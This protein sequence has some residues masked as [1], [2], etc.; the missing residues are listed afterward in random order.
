[1]EKEQILGLYKKSAFYEKYKGT[2]VSDKILKEV[3][4]ENIRVH[5]A[6]GL[7]TYAQ[8]HQFNVDVMKDLLHLFMLD[9]GFNDEAWIWRM[10][11]AFY[12][13]P[14]G[15][16]NESIADVPCSADGLLSIRR[17]YKKYGFS[18]KMIDTYEH[19]R[20]RSIFFFPQEMNGINMS[21]ASVFGDRI[22]HTLLDLKRQFEK[23]PCKLADAYALPKTSQ[24]LSAI[25]TF[26]HLVDLYGIR[27][28]FVNEDNEVYDLGKGDGSILTEYDED[29][30]WDWNDAYYE[31]VK[32]KMDQIEGR[33]V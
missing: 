11:Y 3:F 14:D 10:I 1:M 25:G 27:G 31:N 7:K 29:Y 6:D 13:D 23:K 24:W 17:I 9:S 22:D 21:R 26:E 19:Y 32:K 30:T 2:Y 5:C 28:V 18:E 12:L 20:K 8:V 16:W 33:D 4:G 15:Y